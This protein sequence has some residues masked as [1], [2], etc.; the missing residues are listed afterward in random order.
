MGIREKLD[1]LMTEAVEGEKQSKM[2]ETL[3]FKNAAEAKSIIKS[4]SQQ[5]KKGDKFTIMDMVKGKRMALVSDNGTISFSAQGQPSMIIATADAEENVVG[6]T[7]LF[8]DANAAKEAIEQF[9]S[10]V[11][12]TE[13]LKVSLAVA[14]KSITISNNH[15]LIDLMTTP[16]TKLVVK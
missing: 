8:K 9:T 6:E 4:L 14:N 2:S 16:H 11:T 5:L 7:L 15:L 10:D 12:K 3:K 1:E 13:K